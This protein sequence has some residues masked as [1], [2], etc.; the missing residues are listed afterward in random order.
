MINIKMLKQAKDKLLQNN[1]PGRPDVQDIKEA[2]IVY[3]QKAYYL[4]K[5]V[6]PDE[7]WVVLMKGSQCGVVETMEIYMDYE[8]REFNRS[9]YPKEKK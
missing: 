1:R 6:T 8:Y 4:V 3:Y 2:Q 5:C 9:W 7:K